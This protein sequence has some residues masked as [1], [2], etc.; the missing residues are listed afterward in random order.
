MNAVKNTALLRNFANADIKVR[1]LVL[2]VKYWAKKRGVCDSRNSTLSSYT[3]AILA[4]HFLQ[5]IG[6]LGI[7][8]FTFAATHPSNQSLGN[9][10][11]HFFAYYCNASSHAF[12]MFHDVV[13]IWPPADLSDEISTKESV[14]QDVLDCDIGE[15]CRSGD[16][17]AD[18]SVHS[19][20]DTVAAASGNSASSLLTAKQRPWWRMCIQDPFELSRDLG[21][22]ICRIE[23]QQFILNE[24]RRGFDILSAEARSVGKDGTTAISQLK[25]VDT[26]FEVNTAVPEL[27]PL[28][29]LC[30]A[31][32]HTAGS[33]DLARCW[34]CNGRGHLS[35]DCVSLICFKCLKH[36]D[37]G[38][39]CPAPALRSFA[40]AVGVKA[41]TTELDG[42]ES[43]ALGGSSTASACPSEVDDSIDPEQQHSES[44]FVFGDGERLK[45]MIAAWTI[46]D[47]MNENLVR[48]HL[49]PIPQC[50]FGSAMNW[51]NTF[52][53]FVL[54]NTRAQL[55]ETLSKDFS[56]AGAEKLKF[57]IDRISLS[58]NEP[59]IKFQIDFDTTGT[60]LDSR[61]LVDSVLFTVVLLVENCPDTP[62]WET[63]LSRRHLLCLI[64]T[65]VDSSDSTSVFRAE[66]AP[67]NR[68]LLQD[69]CTTSSEWTA[70]LLKE[71]F[72]APVRI[73]DALHRAEIPH[74][75]HDIV[76]GHFDRMLVPQSISSA[77]RKRMSW[78]ANCLP[79]NEVQVQRMKGLNASQQ[80]AV[81]NVLTSGGPLGASSI[82]LIKGPPGTPHFD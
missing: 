13:S 44:A 71:L 33:C 47:V 61:A 24:L 25:C 58:A 51:Y 53:Y 64:D 66:V 82:Q 9:L 38:E 39:P 54:E 50:S 35:K 16:I 3:W 1:Q 57:T 49:T 62:T 78:N 79:L 27:P 5:K 55:A 56:T 21:S 67:Q 7:S 6:L 59:L 52:P 81:M 45:A 75:M 36:H 69:I 34:R 68:T 8:D 10:L 28:C 23:G 65:R 41:A 42:K 26:L 37:M 29:K 40:E 77:A 22:V 15:R 11:Y 76:S 73:C 31:A 4:I 70:C 20:D 72:T 43:R 19:A 80:E 12:N 14:D 18:S 2:A 30:G 63:M 32:D 74:F 60:R 48:A 46:R 17:M